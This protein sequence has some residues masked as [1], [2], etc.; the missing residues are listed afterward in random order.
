MSFFLESATVVWME[1]AF[2][3]DWFW[4][5]LLGVG[6]YLPS[7]SRTGSKKML[8]RREW[9]ITF[10]FVAE[11]ECFPSPKNLQV[12][13]LAFVRFPLDVRKVS[14]LPSLPNLFVV[15]VLPSFHFA[16]SYYVVVAFLQPICIFLL[17]FRMWSITHLIRPITAARSVQ[18]Q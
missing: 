18:I 9:S 16:D 2:L 4:L 10:N 13:S 8:Y 3:S 14:G 5:V 12:P 17:I 7:A 1:F 11:S 6:L 15:Q